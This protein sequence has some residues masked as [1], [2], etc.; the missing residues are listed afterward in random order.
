MVAREESS[1]AVARNDV[2]GLT[3]RRFLALG[4]AGAAAL[5]LPL[6]RA[7]RALAFEL[8]QVARDALASSPLVYV[9]PLKKDGSESTCHG[10]VWFVQDG[11]DVVLV[12]AADRWKA[13]SVKGGLD[14]ARL[15]VGDFGVWTSADGKWKGAPSFVAKVSFDA[16]AAARARALAAFSKKYPDEWGKWGP[17]F[18]DGLADGSRVMLRYVPVEP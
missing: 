3:R 5:W 4:T 6:P 7:A 15:W 10:E 17:R 16:D 13:R 8:P 12:T 14:R 2:R 18:R 9:S 1:M 11:S